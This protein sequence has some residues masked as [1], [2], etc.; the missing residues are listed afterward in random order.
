VGAAPCEYADDAPGYTDALAEEVIADIRTDIDAFSDAE[1]AV[2]ENH[3]YAVAAAAVKAHLSELASPDAPAA[4]P[5][6]PEWTDEEEVR[7]SL[8]K[9]WKRKLLGRW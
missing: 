5:P 2:L 3:G 7:V 9:S 4:A 1:A 6:H 8:E